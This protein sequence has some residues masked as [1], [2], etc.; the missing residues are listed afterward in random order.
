[1]QSGRGRPRR[2]CSDRCRG[3]A[4]KKSWSIRQAAR[5]LPTADEI[6]AELLALMASSDRIL[7]E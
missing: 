4:A 1:V 3:A 7:S 5:P 6:M 2:W